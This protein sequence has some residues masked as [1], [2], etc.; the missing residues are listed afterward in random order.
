MKFSRTEIPEIIV[1][2]PE[3]Y[4]DTRG[5]FFETF[6]KKEWEE[7]TGQSLNFCQDNESTSSYGVLRGLHYQTAPYA[8]AKL[9]RVVVGEIL[10]VVVDL[11]KNSITFGQH[12]VVKISEE[13]KKQLFVPKG[14]AH[15][16]VVLSASATVAYKVDNYYNPDVEKG[17]RFDDPKLNIDW[18]LPKNTIQ[19][20]PKDAEWGGLE[21]VVA[22]KNV[23]DD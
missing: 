4:Q 16:F 9:V 18:N 8:Q 21:E 23:S 5:S 6:R 2:E 1:G 10:D 11:R 14:F 17:I 7:I 15:G 22:F 3:V 19:I 13:N 12:V 20:S